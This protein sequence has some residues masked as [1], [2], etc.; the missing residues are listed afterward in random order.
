MYASEAAWQA[1]TAQAGVP[2]QAST[3]AIAG[4]APAVP[5]ATTRTAARKHRKQVPAVT[6][7]ALGRNAA[8]VPVHAEGKET[9]TT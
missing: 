1:G 9:C 5:A 3:V 8:S 4:A 7:Y 6:D 2:S